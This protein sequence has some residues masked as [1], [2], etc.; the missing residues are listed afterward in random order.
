MNYNNKEFWSMLD[1]LVS[2]SEII[3]DRLKGSR[4]P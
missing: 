4:H 1:D 2:A 3:I